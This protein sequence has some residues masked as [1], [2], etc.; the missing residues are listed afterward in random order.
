M[1]LVLAVPSLGFPPAIVF[2][3]ASLVG[4]VAAT[5]HSVTEAGITHPTLIAGLSMLVGALFGL[6]SEAFT[7]FLAVR[8]RAKAEAH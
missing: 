2:G 7:S 5:G 8:V 4:T 3:F 6:A 1:I